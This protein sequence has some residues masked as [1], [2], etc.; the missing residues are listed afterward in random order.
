MF[1]IKKNHS[2]VVLL[3]FYSNSSR[4][5][6]VAAFTNVERERSEPRGE[7]KNKKNKKT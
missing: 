5:R 4:V 2:S 3:A 1:L 6:K 7:R